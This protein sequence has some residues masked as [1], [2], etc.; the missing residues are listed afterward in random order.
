[1]GENSFTGDDLKITPFLNVNTKS[2]YLSNLT[3]TRKEFSIL[4]Q[5]LCEGIRLGGRVRQ[6]GG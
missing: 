3:N 4:R 5:I 2:G 6:G 1:M